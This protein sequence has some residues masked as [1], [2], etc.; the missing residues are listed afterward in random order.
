LRRPIR[1]L[2]FPRQLG[3]AARLPA[4]HALCLAGQIVQRFAERVETPVKTRGVN[5][6]V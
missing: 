2:P 4:R 1:V 6:I 3:I 5:R